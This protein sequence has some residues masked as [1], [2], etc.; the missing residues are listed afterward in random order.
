MKK[1]TDAALLI[2]I[3]NM[4]KARFTT[5]QIAASLGISRT[6]AVRFIGKAGQANL[7]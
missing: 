7:Q 4:V 1:Q 6:E 3:A 5:K 2:A